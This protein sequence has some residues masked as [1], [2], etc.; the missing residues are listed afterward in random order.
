ML[1]LKQQIIMFV[2][3]KIFTKICTQICVTLRVLNIK[4]HLIHELFHANNVLK[5]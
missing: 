2:I 5:D 1:K 4:Y 3:Y